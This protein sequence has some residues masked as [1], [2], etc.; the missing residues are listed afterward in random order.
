MNTSRYTS[1]QQV[2]ALQEES[3]TILEQ[4]KAMDII[5]ASG[6]IKVDETAQLL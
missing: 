5:I 4:V 6:D 2:G 3:R 1:E